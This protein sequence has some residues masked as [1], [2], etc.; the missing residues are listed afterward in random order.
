MIGE[1]NI[2]VNIAWYILAQLIM[3]A[4]NVLFAKISLIGTH[5]AYKIQML[6]GYF[7]LSIEHKANI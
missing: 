5:Q 4:T 2:D 6:A 1:R 3:L 7:F